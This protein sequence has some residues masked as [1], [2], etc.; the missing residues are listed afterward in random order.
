MAFKMTGFSGFKTE[1][2]KDHQKKFFT[3]KHREI[4]PDREGDLTRNQLLVQK[5]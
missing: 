5:Q 3:Q 2:P 1:Q 4:E